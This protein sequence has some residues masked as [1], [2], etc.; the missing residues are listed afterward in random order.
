MKHLL[1]SLTAFLMAAGLMAQTS[2]FNKGD[3]VVNAGIGFGSTLY[4]GFGYGTKIPPISVS[5]EYGLLENLFDV[6][7]LNLG[8]G[9]YGGF[10]TAKYETL[11]GGRD[12]SAF[13]IG[14]RGAFHY[15]F[16][17]DLDTYA[18]LLLG[19]KIESYSGYGDVPQ[20]YRVPGSSPVFSSYV[21]ARYYFSDSFAGMM[22][23]GYGIAWINLGIAFKF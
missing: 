11:T 1:L 4:T 6:D 10:S 9:G 2:V 12:F 22:E 19:F 17:D 14:A 20:D 16:V 8:V 13:I 23:L 3:K 5:L 18:G 7:K 15:T 21:G